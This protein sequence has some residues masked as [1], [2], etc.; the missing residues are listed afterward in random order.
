MQTSNKKAA[1]SFI[2][3]TLLIDCMGWGLIIPV[4]QELVSQLKGIPFNEASP[5]GSYLLAA[6]AGMQFIFSR[7]YSRVWIMPT[8]AMRTSLLV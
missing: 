2:F 6:Y 5:Y 1:L 4:S 7:T 8:S 3:V